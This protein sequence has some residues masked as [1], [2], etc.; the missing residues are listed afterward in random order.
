MNQI[1]SNQYKLIN[2]MTIKLFKHSFIAGVACLSTMVSGQNY[3]TP[4]NH[5]LLPEAYYDQLVGESSGD[6]AF[7]Y[8]MDIAPYE[9]DRQH[10][11]Y[12][13]HFMESEYV[14][15]K[16]KRFG[17]ANATIEEVGKTKA[18]DGV[19]ASLWEVSPKQVKIADYQDLAAILG[20]GSQNADVTAPLVWIGRGE[21]HELAAVDLKG[22]IA[23]TEA[24]GARVHDKVVDAGALGVISFNSPRPLIDP[25]QIPNTGIYSKKPTFCFN[26]TPR[27][28]YALRDRLLRGEQ[29]TV[30]AQVEAT[31]EDTDLEVPTCVIPG[32]DPN[33]EEV[34]FTAHLFEGYVKLGA[35][36]NI[37]GSAALI[38]IVRTLNE[39]FESGRLPRPKR[40]MRF[41][42]VP[43]FQGTIP[44]A[45]Q[46]QEILN[47][48][49]CGINLD[50]VGLWLSKSGSYHCLHRTTMGN[51]HY[52]NDVAES[53]YH[54]MGATNKSFVATGMGRPDALKPVYSLTGSQDPFYYS[55]N[56]HYGYSDHEVLNDW[57]V[58]VPAVIMITWPDNYYH[59]SGDRPSIC[60]P[61][62]LHR[63]IVLAAATAYTIASA[64]D[65]MALSIASE[66]SAG[67]SKRM[68][69]KAAEDLAVLAQSTSDQLMQAYKKAHFNQDALLLNEVATLESVLELAPAS[70]ALKEHIGTLQSLL[71]EKANSH[72]KEIDAAVK[73]RATLLGVTYPKRVELTAEEKAAAKIF[74]HATAKVKESGYGVLRTIPQELLQKYGLVKGDSPRMLLA[75]YDDIAKLTTSGKLSLLDIKKM[76]DAQFPDADSLADITR[77]IQMLKEAGL[78]E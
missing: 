64:D 27:D 76:Q 8:I 59:T 69:L 28:G 35:N 46:H 19:S 61:T 6:R 71:K 18:W 30:H 75:H 34:I 51:P 38:E 58:Q 36:D 47:R 39:L 15:A 13:G 42:W 25:L 5:C 74:P 40:S 70:A 17:I 26:L 12:Q 62:Q 52:L 29:I 1:E 65:Q 32:T 7:Q 2:E 53:F 11:D 49:L 21:A 16:L 54:Y 33:A 73:T 3:T 66:V 67:A 68:A 10:A 37:S 55:I 22:K 78:V 20:Q 57:G 63:A 45:Q 41:L 14:V 43:E 23:V 50:M 9:R 44:W 77:F 4:F 56:A 60:D 72:G 24:A 48:T 31:M